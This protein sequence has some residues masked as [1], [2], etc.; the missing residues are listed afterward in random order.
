[1]K[2]HR[3]RNV[4]AVVGQAMPHQEQKA[5]QSCLDFGVRVD[6]PMAYYFLVTTILT[7][8][9]IQAKLEAQLDAAEARQEECVR[10]RVHGKTLWGFTIIC[11]EC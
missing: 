1:M 2:C 8:R 6:Y 9:L 10:G 11:S 3:F 5:Q 4:K 7:R